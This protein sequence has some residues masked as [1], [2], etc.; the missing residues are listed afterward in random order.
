MNSPPHPTTSLAIL[1]VD[2]DTLG[3][4]LLAEYLRDEGYQVSEAGNAVEALERLRGH[5]PPAH[6][7][8]SDIRMP[9]GMDGIQLADWTR[10]HCPS[11]SV[12]LITGYH[13]GG[14]YDGRHE[15]IQKPYSLEHLAAR[16]AE[17]AGRVNCSE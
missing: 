9:G 17:L 8:I 12:L 15:I 7:L 13:G 14:D 4:T 10:L 11:V 5:D 2:D 1:L 16:V 3:R 6:V